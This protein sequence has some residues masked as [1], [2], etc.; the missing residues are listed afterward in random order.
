M[1]PNFVPQYECHSE[2]QFNK[3]VFPHIQKQERAEVYFALHLQSV[4]VLVLVVGGG[5][6]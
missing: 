3:I 2:Y 5:Q 1:S 6:L 4:A